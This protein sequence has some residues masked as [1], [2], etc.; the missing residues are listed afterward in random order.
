MLV[1]VINRT[2]DMLLVGPK[3]L[4]PN[5]GR[6]VTLSDFLQAR[7]QHGAGLESPDAA[8]AALWR[9]TERPDADD[10]EPDEYALAVL[11]GEADGGDLAALS[12]AELAEMARTHGIVPGRKSKRE[13]IEAIHEY[14]E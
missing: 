13:L 2:D 7:A 9:E 8:E 11:D 4:L 10:A 6:R 14:A 5:E 12:R 1:T 3:Y